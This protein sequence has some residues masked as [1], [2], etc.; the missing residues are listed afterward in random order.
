[1]SKRKADDMTSPTSPPASTV[2]KT[3]SPSIKHEP[4]PRRIESFILRPR[5][6]Q[7]QAL[8]PLSHFAYPQLAAVLQ[9]LIDKNGPQGPLLHEVASAFNKAH[10][11][12]ELD[13][14]IWTSFTKFGEVAPISK[15]GLDY[16]HKWL[17][18][19]VGRLMG[20][21]IPSAPDMSWMFH[22]VGA[23]VA[24]DVFVGGNV[25]QI[26][27]AAAY[28][29]GVIAARDMLVEEDGGEASK[30]TSALDGV[31]TGMS[32]GIRRGILDIEACLCAKPK[33]D[34]IVAEFEPYRLAAMDVKKEEI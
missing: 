23:I 12:I 5:I 21:Q 7:L 31:L 10:E 26:Q 11:V 6:T 9:T 28:L 33:F 14:K 16:I 34:Q 18:V 4:T 24:K 32:N 20:I 1:M 29:D 3:P 15:P 22:F 8:G 13:I 19:T 30:R 17:P 25:V 2:P 27:K